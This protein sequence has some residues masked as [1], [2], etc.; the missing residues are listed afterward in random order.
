MCCPKTSPRLV[1]HCARIALALALASQTAAQSE[2]KPPDIPPPL[3]NPYAESGDKFVDQKNWEAATQAY[4]DALRIEPDNVEALV[5]LGRVLGERGDL[6]A[7]LAMFQE[8][9]KVKPDSAE[10][11]N[12]M[13]WYLAAKDDL[14]GAIK[15]FQ[16][17][18]R[19]KPDYAKGHFNLAWA[20]AQWGDEDSALP[21]YQA[22][23]RL[24]PDDAEAHR[25]IGLALRV[26][27]DLDGSLREYREVV[28]LRPDDGDAHVDL[29]L[30]LVR[31]KDFDGA[32]SEFGEKIRLKPD[33]PDAHWN[34]AW[35]LIAKKNQRAA[36]Q[37]L[38]DAVK[39]KPDDPVGHVT[40]GWALSQ[41]QDYDGAIH[42]AREAIR[43]K[44]SY[45]G[46]HVLQARALAHQDKPDAA[47]PEFREALR[48]KPDVFEA[49]GLFAISLYDK[50]DT[51]GA[52]REARGSIRLKPDYDVGHYYLGR[53]LERAGD[54]RA[55]LTE[56]RKALILDRDDRTYREHYV[57]VRDEVHFLPA[58]WS[59]S[60]AV[61]FTISIALV[62]SFLLMSY[63]RARDLYPEP[64]KVLWIT[65]GLGVLTVYP[66]LW[67][68][69]FL[70]PIVQLFQTPIAHGAADAFFGAA[71]TEELMK[72]AVVVLFCARSKEFDEPMD[73][74]VYGAIASLGFA[75]KENVAYVT[76]WG[77][78][79]A[80]WRAIMSVPG[81]ACMG[82]L[83]GYFV[84][85]WRFGP[86]ER[87]KN[88][89]LKALLVPIT[90]HWLYDFPMIA[91]EAASGVKG[92]AGQLALQ[93]L[94]W[95]THLPE[96]TFL[97]ET[98]WV[99][100]LVN[101]LHRQQIRMTRD[102]A[103]A[104]AADLGAM[105]LVA[106]VRAPERPRNWLG[107]SM[108]IVGGLIATFGAFMSI[109]AAMVYAQEQVL[110]DKSRDLF[111]GSMVGGIPLV[112]GLVLFVYGVKSIHAWRYKAPPRGAIA[113]AAAT[114]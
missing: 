58:N 65:F 9:L 43:L 77:I 84:G 3:E 97:F 22:A 96:A 27:G 61:A 36:L 8:A 57:R 35:A 1:R 110:T 67:L 47:L 79:T 70:D 87:R 31:K 112:L 6:R 81:H 74:I 38:R 54:R 106:M 11:H 107:W 103:A 52:I 39:R 19:L 82:A 108:T 10:A 92:P 33:D 86:V 109:V 62:P 56:Y 95:F 5:G 85:Q 20:L 34:L 75:T 24:R 102:A 63:F 69:G 23:A 28:R 113:V 64:A 12:G 7:S 78:H 71:L 60:M 93:R 4:R 101:R 29:G 25:G 89:L 50:G 90:L 114:A 53:G 51:A 30:A 16:E 46:A 26:R 13:G 44:P 49:H 94:R 32:I 76:A 55:A 21:E 80:F 72:F 98:V 14:S 83:M 17:A 104:A 40:L 59:Y 15:E 105:D 42:E 45:A 88:A 91:A 2:T 99:V 48:L 37:Q 66:V 41:Q 100:W 111:L 73:G 18:V 68:D